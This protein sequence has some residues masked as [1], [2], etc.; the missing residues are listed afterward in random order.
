[1]FCWS[2]ATPASAVSLNLSLESLSESGT[3]GGDVIFAG[4]FQNTGTDDVFLNGLSVSFDSPAGNY[5]TLDSNFFF[6]NVPGVLSFYPPP[7]LTYAGDIF[8]IHV[9]SLTPNGIY[10]GTVHIFGGAD[11]D[12]N[13]ELASQS[14]ALSIPEPGG[15][16][17]TGIGLLAWG[18]A[19]PK[20]G[21][22][23]E[24]Q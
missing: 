16:G 7:N 12:A 23:K 22:T 20:R 5:L 3:K 18:I 13:Q 1:M 8:S 4:I 19:K 2:L 24:R 17:L 21:K 15:L 14:F 10:T 11:F 9:S 6:A